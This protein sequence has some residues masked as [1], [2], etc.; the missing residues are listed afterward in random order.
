MEICS[1]N[2]FYGH[3]SIIKEYCGYDKKAPIPMCIQHG[4]PTYKKLLFHERYNEL[5][6]DYWVYNDAAKLDAVNY[7]NISPHSVHVLGAPFAYLY[8]NLEGSLNTSE[9]S[10]G[11]IAFPEHSIPGST[12]TGYDEYAELLSG[13]SADFHPI[14]VSVH[15]HD[16]N[17]NRHNVFIE[18]GM[19]V[20]TCGNKSPLQSNFLNNFVHFCRGKRF[21]TS[22]RWASASIYAMMLG[23][24]YFTLGKF[25]EYDVSNGNQ[26]SKMDDEDWKSL[27]AIQDQFSLSNIHSY[28][29][30]S[31]QKLLAKEIL[32]YNNLLSKV[33]LLDYI[34]EVVN[35]E[36]YIK[37]LIP[38]AVNH[39][40]YERRICPSPPMIPL[41]SNR[42]M[43]DI[44]TTNKNFN[45]NIFRKRYN[46]KLA[47]LKYLNNIT[48]ACAT[49][50][51]IEESVHSLYMCTLMFNF[52]KV[53]LFTSCEINSSYQWFNSLEIIYIPKITDLVSYSKF[54][55]S[56]LNNFIKTDF[57]MLIQSDGFILNN[58]LWK[59]DFT[60]YDYIG[61]P[62]PSVLQLINSDTN[63]IQNITLSNNRVGNG[64]FSLRS[65]KLLEVTSLIDVDNL[66]LPT[67]SE[68]LII[69]H[70]MYNWLTSNG[71][72]F[73]P[74]DLA[75]DFSFE[76]ELDQNVN[77]LQESFGFHG[78]HNLK[79]AHETALNNLN[80]LYNV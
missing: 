35:K 44:S 63:Q 52:K 56:D 27:F 69:C 34:Q 13:L 72:R 2:S 11:T 4:A 20:I 21:V 9:S 8:K 24:T 36:S 71:L 5:I 22:N 15:P 80:H 32:G 25:P 3:A 38:T 62:W 30:N 33:D 77:S 65:K 50:V 17:L 41:G 29:S 26:A 75:I 59:D 1:V 40:E 31:K 47:N 45:S 37:K 74:L 79:I 76:T 67:L 19:S 7:L 73:A 49:S 23:L 10:L 64:G 57:C 53:I 60:E 6:F 68:D 18:K 14:T 54:I 39:N 43:N 51:N 70:Y 46:S 42:N 48:L 78:K 66:K 12:V 16:I 61:A 28:I 58:N 55:L